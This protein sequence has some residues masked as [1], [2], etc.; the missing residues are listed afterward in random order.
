MATAS[1]KI[2]LIRFFDLIRGALS[3]APTREEPVNRIP[4]HV[5]A[6]HS[7]ASETR[8][9]SHQNMHEMMVQ[10]VYS[11]RS[12]I[13]KCPSQNVVAAACTNR[14]KGGGVWARRMAGAEVSRSH[15]NCFFLCPTHHAAPTTDSPIDKP[16][17]MAP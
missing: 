15:C 8:E 7:R 16:I 5:I 1:Q 3:A 6:T 4:L 11:H 9:Y 14:G 13:L 17:P 10:S 12:A 2:I